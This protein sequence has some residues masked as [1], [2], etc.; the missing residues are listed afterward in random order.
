[1]AHGQP[2][3]RQ[4][5]DIGSRTKVN[6]KPVKPQDIRKSL[7]LNSQPSAI[8]LAEDT[9]ASH[10]FLGVR[11]EELRAAI[12]LAGLRPC[13]SFQVVML[14]LYNGHSNDDV[15]CGAKVCDGRG[16]DLPE[17]PWDRDDAEGS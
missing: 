17:T 11:V 10:E 7:D 2:A 8:A 16:A 9:E 13:R 4:G 3:R 14:D 6:I 5:H 15:R 12:G 1:M